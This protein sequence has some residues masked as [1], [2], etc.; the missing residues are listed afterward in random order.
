MRTAARAAQQAADIARAVGCPGTIDK[1][2][3]NRM[4]KRYRT[5]TWICLVKP[6]RESHRGNFFGKTEVDCMIGDANSDKIT[7]VL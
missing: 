7:G 3:K 1:G 6:Y 5:F 2:G 4:Q